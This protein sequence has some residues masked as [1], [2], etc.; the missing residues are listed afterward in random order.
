MDYHFEGEEDVESPA[1]VYYEDIIE[2]NTQKAIGM[3]GNVERLWPHVKTYKTAPMVRML[4][5]RGISRFK[6]ATIAE[7]EMCAQCGAA[8]VL[9]S[10]PLVG[11][12]I[13][14]FIRLRQRYAATTFW[15]TGD[16]LNQAAL[17][18]EAAAAHIIPFLVDINTGMNRTGV[19]LDA[20][21]DF[22]LKAGRLPGLELRGLHCYDGH[23]G[24]KDPAEREKAVA[25][26]TAKLTAAWKA[27]ENA[28]QKLPVIVMGGTPTFPF[29]ARNAGVF[30]SPGTFFVQDHGY[31]FKYRDLDFT[32]GAA[33]LTRVISRPAENL[34]TLDLG[35]KAIAADPA[36]ERGVIADLPGARPQGHSEEHWVFDADGGCPPVGTIL[37]VIPTHICPT[38]ALYPGVHVVRNHKLVNYWEI[39]ARNRK[40]T[41]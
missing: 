30:L 3:A 19:A 10:Y 23:L 39:T 18:G 9:V 15:A 36:A 8:H 28:G 25:E 29:H 11:P 21:P 32:P 14:R 2:K 38:T 16:D 7:A 17:L 35:Y 22:C 24:I 31:E 1:L 12:A 40:I 41:I 34:F 37:Y 27:V 6:C 20:L 33:I 5:A 4:M 26:E 13:G